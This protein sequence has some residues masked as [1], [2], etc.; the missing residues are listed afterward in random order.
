M[1]LAGRVF[2]TQGIAALP[3]PAQSEKVELFDNF[4]EDNDPH[5]ELIS[6]LLNM[7]TSEARATSLWY[8]TLTGI[9][10]QATLVVHEGNIP[11]P[12]R[13]RVRSTA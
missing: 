7:K 12:S 6:G 2:Q 10:G 1:A 13:S 11:V 8:G 9:P 4:T 5:G 3:L